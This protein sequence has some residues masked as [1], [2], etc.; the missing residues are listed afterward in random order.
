MKGTRNMKENVN[1]TNNQSR[2]TQDTTPM[3]LTAKVKSKGGNPDATVKYQGYTLSLDLTGARPIVVVH[4]PGVS[5]P[6]YRAINVHHAKAHVRS[7]VAG[8]YRETQREE[9]VALAD[10]SIAEGLASTLQK[11]ML[12]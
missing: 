12:A 6:I 1:N 10:M 11:R 3:N 9:A 7:L 2:Q 5:R 8:E 4:R